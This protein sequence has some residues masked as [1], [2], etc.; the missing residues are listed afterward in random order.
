M[1]HRRGYLLDPTDLSYPI[2]FNLLEREPAEDGRSS[3]QT[4]SRFFGTFGR[5]R[6]AHGQNIW[7]LCA[8]LAVLDYR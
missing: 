2:G 3:P 7:L 6:G 4:S 5:M 8:V 1:A